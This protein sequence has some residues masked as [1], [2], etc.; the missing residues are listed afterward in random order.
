[1]PGAEPDM[2]AGREP[3][4]GSAWLEGGRIA[5]GSSPVMPEIPVTSS[6]MTGEMW[7]ERKPG[8][9]IMWPPSAH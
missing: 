5:E 1:M 9:G 2:E 3:E 6:G 7:E 8:T 4:E